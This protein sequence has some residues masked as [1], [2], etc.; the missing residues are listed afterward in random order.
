MVQRGIDR[1]QL[2]YFGTADPAHYGIDYEYLPS[3][4]SSCDLRHPSAKA[5]RPHVSSPSVPMQYQGI[6]FPEEDFYRFLYRY[7]PND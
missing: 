2:S 7:N 3:A 1:I 4:N 6:D 5:N